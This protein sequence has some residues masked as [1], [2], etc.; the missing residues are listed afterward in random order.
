MAQFERVVSV[1]L[2]PALLDPE[3]GAIS[4]VLQELGF[5]VEAV[6]VGRRIHLTVSAP[7]GDAATR[8]CAEMAERVLANPVLETWRVEAPES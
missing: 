8:L 3:G 5:P 6:R 4:G 7:D 2:K 1:D